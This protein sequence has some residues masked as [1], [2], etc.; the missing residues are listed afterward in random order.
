MTKDDAIVEIEEYLKG[1]DQAIEDEEFING[2]KA[3]LLTALE[4]IIQIET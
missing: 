2:W 3:A 1:A 4:I